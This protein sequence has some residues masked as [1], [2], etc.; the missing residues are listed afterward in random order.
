MTDNQRRRS[1]LITTA[2]IIILAC[3][4]LVSIVGHFLM[5]FGVIE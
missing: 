5:M 2:M 3:T 4:T 1:N